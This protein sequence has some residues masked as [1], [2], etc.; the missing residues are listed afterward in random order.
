MNTDTDFPISRYEVHSPALA[1]S[2]SSASDRI[3]VVLCLNSVYIQ[4]L[5]EDQLH[6]RVLLVIFN[7]RMKK[8]TALK[9]V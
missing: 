7:K 1:C 6:V 8:Q 2:V 3:L 9:E 5:E 4:F